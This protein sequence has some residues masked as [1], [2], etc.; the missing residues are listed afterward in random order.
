MMNSTNSLSRFLSRVKG[1]LLLLVALFATIGIHA[2]TDVNKTFT[3]CALNID[4]LPQTMAGIT[5]NGDGPGAAGTQAIGL[6]IVNKGIDILGLSE[7]FN[8]NGDLIVGLNQI[9]LALQY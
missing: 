5:V 8:Y 1:T 2:Q 4:G 7:D 6:Y 3:A 9:W